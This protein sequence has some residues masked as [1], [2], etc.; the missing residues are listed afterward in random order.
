MT[1]DSDDMNGDLHTR[2]A[3]LGIG[4]RTLQLEAGERELWRHAPSSKWQSVE[5]ATL[6][7]FE[8][9]GWAGHAQERSLILSLIKAASF[10]EIPSPDSSTFIEAIYAQNV[11]PE[12][13]KCK[14]EWLLRNI[15]AADPARIAANFLAMTSPPAGHTLVFFP[16]LTLSKMLGLHAALGNERLHAIARLFAK[17]PYM[18]RSGWPDLTLWRGQDVVFKEVKA[19]GD[20]LQGTQERII[21]TILR[22]LGYDVELVDIIPK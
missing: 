10:P 8:A 2:V 6:A 9:D 13:R 14:K 19:P 5:E 15:L 1:R 7:Y 3:E 21:T 17:D 20:K 18:Q 22:P 11:W 12:E 4:Y 16:T